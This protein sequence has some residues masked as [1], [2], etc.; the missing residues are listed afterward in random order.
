LPD[1][2]VVAIASSDAYV[3]GVLS[4]RPHVTWTRRRGVGGTLEDRPRYTKSRCFDPFPL[5][6]A[7]DAQKAIIRTLAEELDALRKKVIA[8]HDFLTMT[9]LY[10]VREKLKA[11]TPLDERE[12][13]IH[14]AGC[15]G[16][17]HE[18]HNKIDTAV[19]EAYGW[20]A[21]VSDEDILARFVALNRE[22]AE[23]ERNGL[24]RWLRPEYQIPRFGE[25]RS[26]RKEEQIEA[27]L[28]APEEAAPSLPKDD[29]ALI[30]ALRRTLRAIGKPAEPIEIAARFRE[31]RRAAKRVERGLQLLAAAG[32]A[33]RGQ[34]GWFVA[35][36]AS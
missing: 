19:A 2:M 32:V 13:A 16:V 35:D 12:K 27:A 15:V 34:S 10:N 14:D 4:S 5:P 26:A 28:E 9:K 31:G 33:R 36:R 18:L 17:I 11:G 3:L 24:V 23:E 8:E 7:T 1:H 6:A 20:P 22:R 30:T 29:A 21:D 25:A